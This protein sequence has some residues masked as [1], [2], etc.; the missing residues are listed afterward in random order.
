MNFFFFFLEKIALRFYGDLGHVL[1][2]L[3][4]NFGEEEDGAGAR[5]AARRPPRP[6]FP[7]PI[8]K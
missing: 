6:L 1:G 8:T 7:L 5:R 3:E 2:W 4:F